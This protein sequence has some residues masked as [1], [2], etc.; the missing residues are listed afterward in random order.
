ME[1]YRWASPMIMFFGSAS[2]ISA[3][4]MMIAMKENF[5]GLVNNNQLSCGGDSFDTCK[6]NK[7][8]GNGILAIHI[9]SVVFNAL[10]LFH[11]IYVWYKKRKRSTGIPF[12]TLFTLA[13]LSS[14]MAIA[15]AGY[16]LYIQQNFGKQYTNGG[17]DCGGLSFDDCGKLGG[18]NTQVFLGL[19]GTSLA[20]SGLLFLS[21]FGYGIIMAKNEKRRRSSIVTS[22]ERD[23]KS[24]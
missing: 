2:A 10:I 17:I 8:Y 14:M 21:I 1:S 7:S 9:L 13:G 23:F 11:V 19:S 6:L 15:A 20:L 4:A 5:G 16:A 3:G 18:Q 22:L 24:L 12:K